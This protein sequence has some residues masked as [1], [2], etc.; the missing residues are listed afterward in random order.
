IWWSGLDV[1][2]QTSYAFENKYFTKDDVVN[3]ILTN[4]KIALVFA[5]T[6]YLYVDGFNWTS[7]SWTETGSSPYLNDDTS[8]YISHNVNNG[9]E[10]WFSF[11]DLTGAQALAFGAMQSINVEFE[12]SRSGTDDYFDFRLYDGTNIYG[13]YSITPPGSY[14]WRSY[15]VTSIIK[16]PTQVNNLKIMVRYRQSGGSASTVN[17]RRCRLNINLGGWL[18]SVNGN[19]SAKADFMIVN[20]K[21]PTY[22]S[23]L[24]YSIHHGIVR[25]VIH[26]E[27]EWSGGIPNCPNVYS[28]IVISLPANATYYT[29]RLRLMFVSSQQARTISSLNLIKLSIPYTQ[30]QTEN[31]TSAGYPIVS[32]ETASFYNYSSSAWQHHW[33]QIFNG[34]KGAGIMFTDE[35]N[36]KLYV[37]DQIAG[38]KTGALD[39]NSTAGTIQLSPVKLVQASFT[40]AL[41]VTWNGAIA[42]FD[43]T[44]PIYEE[45]GGTQTGLWMLVEYPPW[46]SVSTE[47]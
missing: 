34:T 22:G 39:V 21:A 30:T 32:N 10:G 18:T 14:D 38:S 31:G 24:A 12:C 11:A 29:Y 43:G 8:N 13:P 33:S 5:T 28:Q 27:A 17:I 40:Y 16:T 4:E 47:S 23:N 45:S 1:T 7:Q 3:G 46:V 19:V 25:D 42:T 44:T 9:E 15:S 20:D 35:A 6:H 2:N 36:Q 41:D 26:Q 37:F